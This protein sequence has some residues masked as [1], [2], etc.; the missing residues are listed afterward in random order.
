[1]VFSGMSLL[2][3]AHHVHQ[4]YCNTITQLSKAPIATH[5]PINIL[6]QLFQSNKENAAS[7][8]YLVHVW[9]VFL[10]IAL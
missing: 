6:S 4:N 3:I 5:I 1:M 2:V 9:S 7:A 10:Y 8:A